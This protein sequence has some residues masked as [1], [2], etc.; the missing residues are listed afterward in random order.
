MFFFWLWFTHKE[1]N[2]VL[3]LH[4]LSIEL[5]FNTDNCIHNHS[6]C[7]FPQTFPH[8]AL[9][10]GLQYVARAITHLFHR[11]W[12]VFS[13]QKNSETAALTQIELKGAKC[14]YLM[15]TW[16][17]SNS[18]VWQVQIKYKVFTG[19]DILSDADCY[20]FNSLTVEF[21]WQGFDFSKICLFAIWRV[22]A[23]FW[24]LTVKAYFLFNYSPFTTARDYSTVSRMKV[25]RQYISLNMMN[26]CY[27]LKRNLSLEEEKKVKCHSK[28]D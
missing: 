15:S 11:S 22:Y 19:K 14:V 8:T 9:Y 17:K 27:C 24:F 2:V 7:P 23:G 4:Y 1:G 20:M 18:A 13:F 5:L 25:S 28:N 26:S 3:F 10:R 16:N 12:M 21:R 6:F